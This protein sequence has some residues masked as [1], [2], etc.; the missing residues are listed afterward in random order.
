MRNGAWEPPRLPGADRPNRTGPC[1]PVCQSHEKRRNSACFGAQERTRTFTA[2]RP[3]V[4]E[5][6]ASTNSATWASAAARGAA[7][8]GAGAG[9][10]RS[11]ASGRQAIGHDRAASRPA[12]WRRRGRG[13]TGR[14]AQPALGVAAHARHKPN[15]R[16]P[17]CSAARASSAATWCSASRGAGH[18]VR[19]AVTRPGRGALPPDPGQG[20]ADRAARGRRGR[21]GGGGA[22]GRRRRAG[23]EPGGHPVRA[24]RRRFRAAARRKAPA[25]SPGSRRRRAPRGWCTSRP[26]AP[27]RRA[28]APTAAPRRRARRRCARP[29]RRRRSCG[30]PSC[31]GRRTA[32]STASPGWRGCCP[33]CR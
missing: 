1:G 33:S 19:V 8:N 7:E 15:A 14:P 5:T 27:T 26:S 6:C 16:S 30:P 32:S 21:R 29:S 9:A 10:C 28:R 12:G 17:P 22:R 11:A 13:H 23:G 20:R 25:A 4:P 2:L 24:A 18:T 3:Q 31:S